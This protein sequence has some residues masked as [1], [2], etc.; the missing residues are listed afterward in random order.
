MKHANQAP[1]SWLGLRIFGPENTMQIY[2]VPGSGAPRS[3]APESSLTNRTQCP[4]PS[5]TPA[6][7]S[8]RLLPS[9]KGLNSP[10][11]GK[12]NLREK[13]IFPL[14]KLLRHAVLFQPKSIEK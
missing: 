10:K 1:P 7:Q 14:W 5:P 6:P 9:L 13:M 11:D 8:V 2:A 3:S 12:N 4:P